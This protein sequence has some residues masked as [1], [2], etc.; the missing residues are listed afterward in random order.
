[1]LG[2]S[3]MSGNAAMR[4]LRAF[5]ASLIADDICGRSIGYW[6]R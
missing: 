1:M 4:H 2:V 6:L 5:W 3:L